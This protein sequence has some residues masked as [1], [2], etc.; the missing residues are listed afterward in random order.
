M[1]IV[2]KGYVGDSSISNK[3]N[4]GML[5]SNTQISSGAVN[6]VY[7]GIGTGGQN[8]RDVGY[9]NTYPTGGGTN[10]NQTGSKTGGG[11]SSGSK[12]SASATAT[13][14]ANA[15]NALLAAYKQNDYSD[16]LRQMR[17]AAQNAYDRG[18][19]ALNDAYDNQLN[20]LSSNLVKGFGIV[21]KSEIDVFLE[22]S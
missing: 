8:L 22:L 1:A 13:N 16:Y 15:Y 11:S 6:K 9:Y 2:R 3:L 17:E 10:T 18:M 21:N 12:S 19:S 7:G 4:N 20:S 5:N 14:T